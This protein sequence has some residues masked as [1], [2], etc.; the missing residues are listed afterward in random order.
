MKK[1]L[2]IC[3]LISTSAFSQTVKLTSGSL[4]SL[5]NEKTVNVEFKY[6]N[7]I[8]G[9]D[10]TEADYVKRKK[11]EYNEKEAGRGDKWEQ[12]WIDDRTKRFEPQFI[13]LF[14]K[15]SE[16]AVNA[17]A[18]YTIIF[19]TTRTEPGFNVGV[20]RKPARIDAL[21]TIVESANHNNVIAEL[22]VTNAPGGGA[23]VTIL[24]LVIEF[25]KPMQNPE[26]KSVNLSLSR[27]V[28]KITFS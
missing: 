28:N 23:A 26:K 14:Q 9:K 7:M 1:I 12:L 5:K 15:Y 10:L 27:S 6:D 20:A 18:K 11:E 13:E 17:E 3:L 21:A 8:V 24:T 19:H 2:F 4:T 16:R 25:R 22:T